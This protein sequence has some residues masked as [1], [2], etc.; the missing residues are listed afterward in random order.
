MQSCP[1]LDGLFSLNLLLWSSFIDLTGFYIKQKI[2]CCAHSLLA[3]EKRSSLLAAILRQTYRLVSVLSILALFSLLLVS[4]L[5]SQVAV[6]RLPLQMQVTQL[7][8]RVK[9]IVRRRTPSPQCICQRLH[10]V[11]GAPANVCIYGYLIRT[12]IIGHGNVGAMG[13]YYQKNCENMQKSVRLKY[14]PVLSVP[15][16]IRCTFVVTDATDKFSVMVSVL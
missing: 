16:L 6:L 15:K 7:F 12:F 11:A 2:Y 13:V 3:L 5:V 1:K 8:C 4:G 14:E 9:L 10:Q